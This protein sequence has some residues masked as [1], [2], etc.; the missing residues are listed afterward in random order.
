MDKLLIFDPCGFTKGNFC[1]DGYKIL[2]KEKSTLLMNTKKIYSDLSEDLNLPFKVFSKNK[3]IKLLQYIIN[4]GSLNSKLKKN[5]Y[6]S[7]IFQMSPIPI[8]DYIFFKSIKK[9]T[10]IIFILHNDIPF[11]G[12]CSFFQKF[13][14]INLIK[15]FD[16]VVIHTE[17]SKNFL[18]K[19]NFDKKKIIKLM[20]P[21]SERD[22]KKTNNTSIIKKIN[23]LFF[24]VIRPY[25]GLNFFLENFDKLTNEIQS[26]FQITICGTM[27]NLNRNQ[28]YEIIKLCKKYDNIRLIDNFVSDKYKNK[29]FLKNNFIILTYKNINGSGVA[30][31]AI[32]YLLPPITTKLK[33]F[34]EILKDS[35]DCFMVKN[36]DQSSIKQ[37]LVQ[38]SNI[39]NVEYQKMKSNLR[40]TK[41]RMLN[42]KEYWEKLYNIN[43]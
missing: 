18:N 25:K 11:H 43:F 22:G 2:G 37:K 38:I 34:E 33:A 32:D 17:T 28:K 3:L 20:L 8:I 21:I 36:D 5:K 1:E 14:Y 10:K 4:L 30:T 26:K 24:G 7:I 29:L 19:C 39:T 13:F 27:K 15:I 31:D 16:K 40:S 35:F 9:K 6:K 12:D 42:Q 23:L 41:K